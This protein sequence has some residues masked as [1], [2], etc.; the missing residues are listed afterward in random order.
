MRIGMILLTRFPPD[1][2]VEKEATTLDQEHDIFLLCTRRNGQPIRDKWKGVQIKR[3]FSDTKRWWSNW[4]LLST[5]FS[6][7][8]ENEMQ[9]FVKEFR[10]EVL[11]V[12][13]L[14][15]LGT[16]IK[17]GKKLGLPVVSDLH[18]NYPQMLAADRKLPLRKRL[19]PKQ[20][21]LQFAVSIKK[22]S[23]YER[24]IVPQANEVIT[25]IEEARDRLVK[26][27]VSSE[28]LHVVANY[29]DLTGTCVLG[30][31]RERAKPSGKFRIIYAGAFGSTRDLLTV[32]RAAAHISK[33]EIPNLEIVLVGGKGEKLVELHKHVQEL[34]V[35]D[36]V[37]LRE[38]RPL[39]EIEGLIRESHVGL[40]PHVK[41][42]HTDS[43]IPH[44][45]FQYMAERKPVIVSNCAPLER[46]VSE[47]G[48]GLVYRSGDYGSLA[49]C[50][51]HLYISPSV[52]E[53]MGNAGYEAV[54]NKYNW[55]IAGRELLRV[56]RHIY[57]V[58]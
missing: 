20:I 56:Y 13:D 36:R 44:K 15:L 52:R 35:G 10:I 38:W 57:V 33:D 26:L 46:I 28:H 5:C 24:A 3:I 7:D 27:G 18:E 4:R 50:A 53:Q 23:E 25:V 12:H 16:A 2:R 19:N 1:I 30:S 9:C 49:A 31:D 11:H 45:L 29:A 41:S 51:K 43:T 22:W 8:W 34:S 6:R 14:P 17:V 55:N 21:V 48:C 54:Q 39:K 47:S 58:T 42:A 37:L 32:I 40:V